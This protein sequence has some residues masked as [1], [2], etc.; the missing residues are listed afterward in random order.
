[1]LGFL[2]FLGMVLVGSLL[3]AGVLIGA[4]LILGVALQYTVGKFL[5]L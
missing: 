5:N 4:M 3:V 2:Q 1:M